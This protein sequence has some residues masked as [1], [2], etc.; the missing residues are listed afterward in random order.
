M[1]Y[2]VTTQDV[3]FTI[4][5]DKLDDCYRALCALN[6]LPDSHKRGGSWSE[7]Q[8]RQAWFSWM[9]P[10]YPETCK[11]A[12]E[13]FEEL[14]FDCEVSP[15]GSLSLNYYDNK[16]GQE[17]LFLEAAAP[18]AM[19]GSYIEWRGEDGEQWLDTVVDGKLVRKT[20]RVVY[21]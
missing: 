10:N 2:Y 15:D 14:G 13:V 11:N 9:E 7:G 4:P 6:D 3:S 18:F 1:G 8:Q 20:G 5:A 19:E 12:Q 16:T 17:D 21:E